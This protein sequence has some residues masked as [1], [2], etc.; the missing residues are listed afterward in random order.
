MKRL[1]L[2]ATIGVALIAAGP[3]LAQVH[4]GAGPGGVGGDRSRT[5]GRLAS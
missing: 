4:F 3:A 2:M 1:F 5:S